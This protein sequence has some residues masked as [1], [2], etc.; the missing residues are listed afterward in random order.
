MTDLAA[1]LARVSSIAA[2]QQAKAAVTRE[3]MRARYPGM[4]EF[5]DALRR[6]GIAPAAITID[7]RTYGTPPQDRRVPPIPGIKS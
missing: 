5:V 6:A 2:Q 3:E 7:G 4:A 1:T